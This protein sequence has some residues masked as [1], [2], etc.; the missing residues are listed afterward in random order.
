MLRKLL[1]VNDL[2][3][4]FRLPSSTVYAVNGVS[5]SVDRGQVLGL[6]GESGCGKSVTA[7][8]IPSLVPKPYGRIVAGQVLFY[9]EQGRPRD[10]VTLPQQQIQKIRGNEISMIFQDPMTSLNPVLTIGYQIMEPLK[11]HRGMSEGEA[12]RAA[13]QLLERVGIPEAEQRLKEYP[14]QFSGGMRQR[15]MIAMAV[16]CHPSLLIADEPSTALDVT[17]QAQILDLLNDLRAEIGTAIIIITH[18]L[19]VIAEIADK[20]AVIYA[21]LVV[22]NASVYDV[23]DAPLHPYTRALMASVPSLHYQPPRLTTI[24][25]TPPT[26]TTVIAGCPFEPRCQVRVNRCAVETPA[27][28]E[29]ATGHS[30]ACWQVTR[31]GVAL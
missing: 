9:D 27:L 31:A 10:L 16:A 23:F 22:E 11:V 15:A 13:V 1:E 28:V 26:L 4:E 14:H 25:G 24:S 8:S 19:G 17:I 5:F 29:V 3:V 6:V 21:G 7:L 18:D 12:R 2:K 20:V 30:C